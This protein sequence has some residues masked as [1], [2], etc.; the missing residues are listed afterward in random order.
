MADSD[1]QPKTSQ[2]RLRK[3]HSELERCIPRFDKARTEIIPGWPQAHSIQ[4]ICRAREDVLDSEKRIPE[5]C[6]RSLSWTL[7][8]V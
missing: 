1:L 5:S 3:R 4:T 8:D 6:G 7:K 2:T